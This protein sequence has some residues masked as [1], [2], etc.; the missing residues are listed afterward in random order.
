MITKIDSIYKDAS[1]SNLNKNNQNKKDNNKK[2]S[3]NKPKID[4]KEPIL[5]K[6]NNGIKVYGNSD[7]KI[8]YYSIK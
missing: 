6:N 7:G 5:L 8:L 2:K 1:N 3:K 4:Y